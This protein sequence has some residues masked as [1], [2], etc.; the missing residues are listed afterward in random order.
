[1]RIDVHAHYWTED[2]IDLLTDLGKADARA[3]L[4]L[5]AGGGADLEARLRLMDRAGI[6]MQVLSAC[7][8]SPY[9]QNKQ[10]MA[11]AAR[12]VNDQYTHLVQG[13]PDRFRAF[14]ALPMPHLEESLGEMGR[15]LDELGMAGVAMNTTVQGQA[16][17]DPGYEPVF[18]ELNR[19][20][21]VLYLH[22]AGNSA[23][24]PLI[25]DYHLTWMVG[26]PVEDTISIMHLITHGIPARYPDITIINSH[27]GGALPMLLQR[28]DDQ[29][30]W[31]APDTPERPSVAARRMWYDTV[32]HGTSP[33]CGAQSTRSART[34]SSS[35]PTSPT[36]T[37]T[38]SSARST[39][40]TTPRST[41]AP[42]A[43]SSTRTPGALLGIG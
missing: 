15:A 19:R 21:A 12:F 40:S 8:Q 5:G 31:E 11:T 41:R 35:E 26:A 13:Q 4:G 17:V 30:R 25:A 24:T 9:G 2:Y 28:A 38:P 33:P 32:G 1:M 43:P 27:L 37:A 14:A 16:L 34:G 36:K 22:P 39:T 10:K 3:A 20:N 42:P 23:C 18:A 7:P 29:Y 6:E